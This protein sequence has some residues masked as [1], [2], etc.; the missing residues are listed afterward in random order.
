MRVYLF[1]KN[2]LEFSSNET[3]FSEVIYWTLEVERGKADGTGSG[4]IDVIYNGQI[5]RGFY[6]NAKIWF[7]EYKDGVY[8]KN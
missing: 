7:W 1:F 2:Y 8:I 6:N 4:Y 3:E 5:G